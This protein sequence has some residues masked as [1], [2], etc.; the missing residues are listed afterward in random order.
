MEWGGR[1]RKNKDE[2]G[3]ALAA[4]AGVEVVGWRET[5][6][7]VQKDMRRDVLAGWRRNGAYWLPQNV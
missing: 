5:V 4:Q 1:G 2:N 7:L 3:N 6:G